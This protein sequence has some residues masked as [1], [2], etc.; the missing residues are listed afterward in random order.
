MLAPAV[1]RCSILSVYVCPYL[2]QAAAAGEMEKL[3]RFVRLHLGFGNEE[4]GRKEIDKPWIEA[5][6]ILLRY[7]P[8]SLIA[9]VPERDESTLAL[10]YFNLHF[11]LIR[12]SGDWIRHG[13]R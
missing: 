9:S 6:M 7:E 13:S 5:L 8:E 1:A 3:I 12:K 2:K 10:L 4:V 11:F